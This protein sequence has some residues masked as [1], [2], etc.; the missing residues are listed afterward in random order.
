MRWLAICARPR[1]APNYMQP[2]AALL[3]Y[4][5]LPIMLDGACGHL[6]HAI[7]LAVRPAAMP[8]VWGV[9]DVLPGRAHAEPVTR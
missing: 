6:S 9:S 8:G 1:C 4:G 2:A 5:P 3:R 7:P